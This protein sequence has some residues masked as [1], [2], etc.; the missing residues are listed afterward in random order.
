M[1]YWPTT[2]IKF[3]DSPS[4]D[5]FDRLRVSQPVTQFNSK[6][7]WDKAPEIYDEDTT[8][9]GASAAYQSNQSMV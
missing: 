6:L 9:S 7:L 3:A 1:T 5:A 8:G 2:A 4:I